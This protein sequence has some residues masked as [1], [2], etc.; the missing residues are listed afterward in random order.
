MSTFVPPRLLRGRHVQSILGSVGPRRRWGRLA[1]RDFIAAS[2]NEIVD[3]GAGVRLLCQHTPPQVDQHKGI[4]VFI[5]G[6]EGSANSTYLL[7][8]A[9]KLWN[10]GYRIVRLN[11]RDHGDSHGLNEDLFHSCRLDEAIG[12]VRWVQQSF[13]G[14]QLALCGFS[15]GGNFSLRIAAQAAE[16]GLEINGVVAVC[17]VLDPARTMAALDKGSLLYKRYFIKKWRTSL[18]KKKAA[19]PHRYDFSKLERF[20]TLTEMTEYF[21]RHYTDYPDLHEYLHGYALTDGRLRKLQTPSRILLAEDDPVIPVADIERVA[22]SD[23]LQIVRS[24]YG[25]HCGFIGGYDLHGWV[26]GY[27]VN[28]LAGT[29]KYS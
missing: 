18:E 17:P 29:H 5:H 11:L 13:P 3:C 28:F 20:D 1:A 21:V 19:F 22:V 12:A 23:Y 26:D 7:S 16:E 2:R 15:L 25:G 24:Q 8:A 6:W 10:E 4:A 27:I 14:E 9:T